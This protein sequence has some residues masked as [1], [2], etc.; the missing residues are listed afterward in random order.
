VEGTATGS[1]RGRRLWVVAGLGAVLAAALGIAGC[2]LLGPEFEPE[3]ASPAMVEQAIESRFVDGFDGSRIHYVVAAPGTPAPEGPAVV[4]VHGSPGTWEAWTRYLDDPELRGR[5]RLLALDRPGFG[6]SS[7]GEAEPS[8]ARQAEAVARV[9]ATEGADRAVI[10]GHSLGGP[11][12]AQLA[13]DDPARVAGLVLFAPSIDPA[14]E[15]RRWYNVAGS[16]L[17]VQWFLPVDWITSNRE[18][19]PLRDE[20]EALAPRLASIEVP[21]VVVQGDRDELVPP[22]NADF[23]ERRLPSEWVEVRRLAGA[24]HFFVWQAYDRA[25][26]AI[27]E[28]LERVAA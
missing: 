5:A 10:V 11:V 12:A 2:S 6:A 16:L 20:L 18:I 25:R 4:F 28:V 3:V 15:R 1:R 22:A 19:W 9:L 23:L 14:L 13:V 8:L 17:V 7:R 27:L 21:T 24:G 26:S